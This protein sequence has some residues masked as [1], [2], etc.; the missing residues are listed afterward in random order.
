MEKGKRRR[1]QGKTKMV[2]ILDCV[3]I[4]VSKK[5]KREDLHKNNNQ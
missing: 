4:S 2:E 1:E 5:E 3:S